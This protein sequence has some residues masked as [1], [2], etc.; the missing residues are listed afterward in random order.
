MQYNRYTGD[1]YRRLY[2][3]GDSLLSFFTFLWRFQQILQNLVVPGKLQSRKQTEYQSFFQRTYSSLH[4]HINRI[5]FKN[6]SWDKQPWTMPKVQFNERRRKRRKS[7]MWL[8]ESH[9]A[10]FNTGQ[11][12]SQHNSMRTFRTCNHLVKWSAPFCKTLDWKATT[13]KARE[14]K[15]VRLGQFHFLPCLA[16]V[17]QSGKTAIFPCWSKPLHSK[18]IKQSNWFFVTP[19]QI[20]WLLPSCWNYFPNRNKIGSLQEEQT[21]P[22]CWARM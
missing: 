17:S 3:G 2:H 11:S 1:A 20:S 5:Y 13:L 4:K 6:P 10:V 8:G 18:V 19:Q 16:Q 22:T 12:P 7:E 15:T 9:T 14:D 21:E